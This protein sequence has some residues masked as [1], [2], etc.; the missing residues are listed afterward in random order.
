MD[1]LGKK[2][3]LMEL[4]DK[5]DGRL[6]YILSKDKL[7][8]IWVGNTLNLT[9]LLT[10]LSANKY[11]NILINTFVLWY[12]IFLSW[13]QWDDNG[14][15]HITRGFIKWLDMDRNNINHMLA[16]LLDLNPT[17]HLWAILKHHSP[18]ASPKHQLRE[19]LLE[20]TC[21]FFLVRFQIIYDKVHS[22]CSVEHLRWPKTFLILLFF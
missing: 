6:M 11:K 16:P 5:R 22:S 1:T 17:I 4:E 10:Y 3:K 2:G 13:W 7:L 8:R 21:S 20:E 15:I 12:F 9:P 19:Y 14:N 18:P